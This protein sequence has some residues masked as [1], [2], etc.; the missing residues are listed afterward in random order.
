MTDFFNDVFQGVCI[1]LSITYITVYFL[2]RRNR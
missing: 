1:G 2:T